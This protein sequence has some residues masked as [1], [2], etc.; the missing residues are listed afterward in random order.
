[1]DKNSYYFG[2]GTLRAVNNML[3]KWGYAQNGIA[4]KNFEKKLYEELKKVN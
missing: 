4:G 2:D 1:M 3:K